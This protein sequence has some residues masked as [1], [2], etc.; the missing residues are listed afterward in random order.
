MKSID[1]S[2]FGLGGSRMGNAEGAEGI[3]L[4]RP[5][6]V[7]AVVPRHAERLHRRLERG[8]V[9][10]RLAEAA[11]ALHVEHRV[12]LDEVDELARRAAPVV[13]LLGPERE[14]L[15]AAAR[16]G[17]RLGGVQP[18]LGAVREGGGLPVLGH[19][20]DPADEVERHGRA[21][22]GA[23]REP[24][25][26]RL[27]VDVEPVGLRRRGVGHARR[28]E[29][30]RKE[31]RGRGLQR[32][33]ERLVALLLLQ[34]EL[35]HRRLELVDGVAR[36]GEDEVL[37]QVRLRE[38]LGRGDLAAVGAALRARVLGPGAAAAERARLELRQAEPDRGRG[39]LGHVDV[40]EP[41]EG[42]GVGVGL[43]F[44]FG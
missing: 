28:R 6:R 1:R 32:L 7:G 33:A 29:L 20:L 25:G 11:H 19:V 4:A 5:P 13:H 42:D 41:G 30:P 23:P 21:E 43:G 36:E 26:A 8:A 40:D 3:G 44:G 16:V 14:Q 24:V 31:L 15:E 10:A 34:P 18:E 37:V 39:R 35:A 2:G 22:R 9:E 12:A 27:E 38:A 17:A